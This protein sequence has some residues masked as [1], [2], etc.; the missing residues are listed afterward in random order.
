[1]QIGSLLA[2]LVGCG[3]SPM[4]ADRVLDLQVIPAHWVE[5]SDAFEPRSVADFAFNALSFP[6][7]TDGWI[8]GDRFLLL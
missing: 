7:P 8:V 4:H 3:C 6:T 5:H 1:V 2:A